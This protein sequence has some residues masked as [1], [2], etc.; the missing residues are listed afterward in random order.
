MTQNDRSDGWSP[1]AGNTYEGLVDETSTDCAS[2]APSHGAVGSV[3]QGSTGHGAA[4]VASEREL[5][6]TA[7][8]FL[9]AGLRAGDLVVLTCPPETVELL[10]RELGERGRPVES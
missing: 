2:S 3:S 9:D 1:L 6:E 5:L 7:L 10:G 4:V 8:P